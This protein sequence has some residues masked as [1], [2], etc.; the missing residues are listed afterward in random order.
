MGRLKKVYAYQIKENKKYKGRYIILI[1]QPEIEGNNFSNLYKVKLTNDMKLTKTVEEINSCEFVKMRACPYEL[2]MFPI[3]GGLN[4][5]EALQNYKD[6][7]LPDSDNN[8][9][10]YDY[11]FIFTRKEK[12]SSLIYIGEF[13]VNDN[14]PYEK[15]TANHYTPAYGFISKLEKYT[16]KGYELNNKKTDFL[17][18]ERERKEYIQSRINFQNEVSVELKEWMVNYNSQLYNYSFGYKLLDSDVTNMAIT[19]YKKCYS[20]N[21]TSKAIINDVMLEGKDCLNNKADSSLYIFGIAYEIMK[22]KREMPISFK[23]KVY[24]AIKKDLKYW[25]DN[26]LYEKRKEELETF[27][28]KVEKYENTVQ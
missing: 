12:K 4:Y 11:S 21:K 15:K 23:K 26:E 2:R 3:M 16:I 10:N 19:D 28:N 1:K 20:K 5:D 9:F 8:L 27:R 17:Y 22:H 24:S 6:A 13:D 18:N 25:T 7:T 14:P